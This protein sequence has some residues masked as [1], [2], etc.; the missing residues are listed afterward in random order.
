MKFR[1]KRGIKVKIDKYYKQDHNHKIP[2]FYAVKDCR[3]FTIYSIS[4]HMKSRNKD[5]Y[6]DLSELIKH[7]HIRTVEYLIR[8]FKK[9]LRYLPSYTRT[10]QLFLK[11]DNT[12]LL[13]KSLRY[14]NIKDKHL[15]DLIVYGIRCHR[16]DAVK[17][18][19]NI[20]SNVHTLL[21]FNCTFI[22]YATFFNNYEITEYLLDKFNVT[23]N[24][25]N[26][27][28]HYP[29]GNALHNKY[30]N[31]ID[32]LLR[33]NANTFFL[34]FKIEETLTFGH[35]S[36]IL[37][38]LHSLQIEHLVEAMKIIERLNL[39]YKP[40]IHELLHSIKRWIS[41]NTCEDIYWRIL[42][43]L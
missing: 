6:L 22:H 4:A 14:R 9:C 37:K 42:S 38:L 36:L 2:L 33:Y 32:L 31:L 8:K 12:Y 13:H 29:L 43:Y 24:V 35:E 3:K 19:L 40:I 10:I 15:N 21:Q 16:N 20:H 18:L 26:A 34:C 5:V 11:Y 30:T 25:C 17:Y 39:M 27:R 7:G 1:K 23:P 28:F 41:T